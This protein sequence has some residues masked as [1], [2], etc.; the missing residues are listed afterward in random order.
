[1]HGNKQPTWLALISAFGPHV[2]AGGISGKVV[3]ANPIDGCGQLH[4]KAA[5]MDS[6]AMV[7]RGTCTFV[8]KVK[9]YL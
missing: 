4:N 1:M 7:H 9:V 3:M 5:M 6:I 2:V 8:E